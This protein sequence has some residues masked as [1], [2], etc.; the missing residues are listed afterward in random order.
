KTWQLTLELAEA[1]VRLV[2]EVPQ[3]DMGLRLVGDR[4]LEL[5]HFRRSV[6]FTQDPAPPPRA[7]AGGVVVGHGLL[8]TLIDKPA[9]PLLDPLDNRFPRRLDLGP[10]DIP[11]LGQRLPHLLQPLLGLGEQRS[12]PLVLLV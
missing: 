8:M 6:G 10:G 2:A 4:L 3:D 5:L 7:L 1:V 9:A 12:H 11:N